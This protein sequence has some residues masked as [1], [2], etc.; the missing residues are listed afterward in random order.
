MG[1][2]ETRSSVLNNSSLHYILFENRVW[3]YFHQSMACELGLF[4][5]LSAIRDYRMRT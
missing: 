5:L 2:F 1:I 3:E 4:T